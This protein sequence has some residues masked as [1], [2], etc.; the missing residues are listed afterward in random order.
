[1]VLGHYITKL[2]VPL[3]DRRHRSSLASH[4][5]RA[6]VGDGHASHIVVV[7]FL[8][9][10]VLPSAVVS[11]IASEELLGVRLMVQDNSKS[12]RKVDRFSSGVEEEVVAAS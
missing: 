6:V 10:D 1:M 7:A 12:C 2:R 3:E 8:I 11:F 9:V 5:K 4:H